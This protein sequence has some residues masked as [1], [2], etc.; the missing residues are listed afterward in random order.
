MKNHLKDFPCVLEKI[1]SNYSITGEKQTL[2]LS[3]EGI[4]PSFQVELLTLQTGTHTHTHTHIHSHS[5]SHAPSPNPFV[6]GGI[7]QASPEASAPPCRLY[8]EVPIQALSLSP[9]V[10][11]G[12]DGDNPLCQGP[13]ASS[14]AEKRVLGC[15]G[16]IPGPRNAPG[17]RLSISDFN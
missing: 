14:D 9:P 4:S 13:A 17:G 7:F 11:H 16:V 15:A 12:E 6:P 5:H 10:C 3:K 8:L 1:P 2:R